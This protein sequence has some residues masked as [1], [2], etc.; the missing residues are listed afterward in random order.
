MTIYPEDYE[1]IANFLRARDQLSRSGNGQSDFKIRKFL[2]DNLEKDWLLKLQQKLHTQCLNNHLRMFKGYVKKTRQSM[3]SGQNTSR[4]TGLKKKATIIKILQ[5]NYSLRELIA[6]N[7]KK[8]LVEEG[9]E[10]MQSD[11]KLKQGNFYDTI[12]WEFIGNILL[13]ESQDT[14]GYH[15]KHN[16]LDLYL[17]SIEGVIEFF[18]DERYLEVWKQK[19]QNYP[20]QYKLYKKETITELVAESVQ[21]VTEQRADEIEQLRQ[22]AMDSMNQKRREKHGN[23]TDDQKSTSS[24]LDGATTR[25]TFHTHSKQYET[26]RKRTRF[27]EEETALSQKFRK[28]EGKR[29]AEP[30]Y[31][32]EAGF[33][34]GVHT[35]K[36]LLGQLEKIKIEIC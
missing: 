21:K 29:T 17:A 4:P 36:Y 12:V 15:N 8:F 26:G 1:I 23:Q 22:K 24:R 9:V 20:H 31:V 14:R 34:R 33:K 19:V 18:R 10:I 27:D 32:N 16:E 13:H 2:L 5:E 28:I 25:T 3:Q 11:E 7:P 35:E 6:K 30:D